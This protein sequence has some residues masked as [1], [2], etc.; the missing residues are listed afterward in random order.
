MARRYNKRDEFEGGERPTS[1]PVSL[2]GL[3]KFQPIRKKGANNRTWRPML[4]SDL[5]QDD[6][7]G[8]EAEVPDAGRVPTM[9]T[10]Q[11]PGLETSSDITLARASPFDLPPLQTNFNTSPESHRQNFIVQNTFPQDSFSHDV[12]PA[13]MAGTGTAITPTDTPSGAV[14]EYTRLFGKV[15]PSPVQLHVQLG[16][17]EGQIAFVGHPTRDVSA[18]QWSLVKLKWLNIGIYSHRR[19]KIQGSL[20]SDRL[21]GS[22]L[23]Q[24]TI[25]YFK[26]VAEQREP[27]ARGAPRVGSGKPLDPTSSQFLSGL[28][29]HDVKGA[30][31]FASLPGASS[32]SGGPGRLGKSFSPFNAASSDTKT[33]T[34][35]F[36]ETFPEDPPFVNSQQEQYSQ[37]F[38]SFGAFT[39]SIPPGAMDFSYRFPTK[40][41]DVD[42]HKAD[43]EQR[44]QQR[45]DAILV[46]KSNADSPLP[47]VG[48]GEEASS[49]R[50]RPATKANRPYVPLSPQDAYDRQQLKNKLVALSDKAL[51]SNQ[52]I[53]RRTA[54][55]DFQKLQQQ[56][57]PTKPSPPAGFTIANPHRISS[58]LNAKA[59]PYVGT[60]SKHLPTDD[61]L[62]SKPVPA[63]DESDAT[64]INDWRRT[65]LKF[66][67]PDLDYVGPVQ[68]IVYGLERYPPT[69][70]NW[71]GPFFAHLL[72]TNQYP[73]TPLAYQ[74]GW[75]DQLRYWYRDGYRPARQLDHSRAM[76]ASAQAEAK[77][78]NPH[79]FG[80]IGESPTTG[81]NKIENT[82]LFARL[83]EHASEY[84]EESRGQERDYFTRAWK[85]PRA[86]QIDSSQQGQRS[87]FGRSYRTFPQQSPSIPQQ[88]RSF[89]QQSRW[90]PQQPRSS[91]R[92][93]R[94]FRQQ[95]RSFA[96][97]PRSFAPAQQS[98]S[99]PRFKGS[100]RQF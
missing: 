58:T 44:E 84:R 32:S 90:F 33:V 28:A 79:A 56:A 98:R 87:F 42:A 39:D 75:D 25:E 51:K 60:V 55:P 83:H 95:S 37:A 41:V 43:L 81:W 1:G 57:R 63:D 48:F 62:A 23:R 36:P 11:H 73:A 53:D 38:L 22:R 64:V 65:S 68:E 30:D 93:P 94:S 21:K 86:Y 47:Y 24:N 96:Q 46:G 20:A 17:F 99:S 10:H 78:R 67:V 45:I 9:P 74:M 7:D 72:P 71:R 54:I 34:R 70:Q 19:R 77:I 76:M 3:I 8:P 15:L 16:E 80:A 6:T 61:G 91:P 50:D 13:S 12:S 89:A 40:I 92:Q 66:S 97:Q 27:A 49:A 4:P 5:D 82:P 14:D 88:P 18:H 35:A 31:H 2:A 85:S 69:P 52:S 100:S 59:K 29:R 26:A